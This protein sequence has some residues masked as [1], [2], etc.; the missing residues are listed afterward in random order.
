LVVQR[1]VY[2]PFYDED[3]PRF[4][5]GLVVAVWQDGKIVRVQRESLPDASYVQGRLSQGELAAVLQ[6]IADSNLA[7][8]CVDYLIIDAPFL[9][10]SLRLDYG[11]RERFDIV[12]GGGVT[13]LTEL[14][15]LLESTELED[16]EPFEASWTVRYA[17]LPESWFE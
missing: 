5:S 8:P 17:E 12:L 10:M 1:R 15:N 7:A 4:W 14:V 9:E 6:A 16:Q 13:G 2:G 3:D 11:L